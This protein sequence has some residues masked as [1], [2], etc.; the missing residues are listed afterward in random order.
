MFCFGVTIR[1]P[2]AAV[3]TAARAGVSAVV[4]DA[5]E[6]LAAERSSPDYSRVS[7]QDDL[8]AQVAQLHERVRFAQRPHTRRYSV[9]FWEH[10]A[11]WHTDAPPHVSV[12]LCCVRSVVPPPGWQRLRSCVAHGLQV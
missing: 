8:A 12:M 9:L 7:L 1:G 3:V 5:A 6:A 4:K 10:T 11:D 2:A